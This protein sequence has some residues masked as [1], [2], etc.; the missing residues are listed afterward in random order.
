VVATIPTTKDIDSVFGGLVQTFQGYNRNVAAPRHG[1]STHS[2]PKPHVQNIIIHGSPASRGPGGPQQ[3]WK[4][5]SRTPPEEP[6]PNA[7]SIAEEIHLINQLKQSID[8]VHRLPKKKEFL[9]SIIYELENSLKIL[10]KLNSNFDRVNKNIEKSKINKD[11]YD[12]NSSY[13]ESIKTWHKSISN[14]LTFLRGLY[15]YLSNIGKYNFNNMNIGNRKKYDRFKEADGKL[16]VGLV[17]PQIH[18]FLDPLHRADRAL[19]SAFQA[20]ITDQIEKEADPAEGIVDFLL[21]YEFHTSHMS[22]T[23]RSMEK[24][25]LNSHRLIFRKGYAYAYYV[26]IKGNK[27]RYMNWRHDKRE[28]II[29]VRPDFYTSAG[30][31]GSG[32]AFRGGEDFIGGDTYVVGADDRFYAFLGTTIHSEY[33]SGHP[34]QAAGLI[35]AKDGKIQAIDNRSGHYQ[36]NWRNLLQAV[37]ILQNHQVFDREAIVGLVSPSGSVMFFTV[38]DCIELGNNNFSFEKTA[39]FVRHYKN[40]YN[41]NI[42]VPASRLKYIPERLKIGWNREENNRWDEF[43]IDFF[44]KPLPKDFLKSLHSNS[45]RETSVKIGGGR[46]KP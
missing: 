30:G 25:R 26:E 40:R 8:K 22:D 18:E 7:N 37:Q 16:I 20:W 33:F 4:R 43:F 23:S 35:V 12:K 44:G 41:G 36:P 11:L 28:E 1:A 21:N 46:S 19:A 24:D 2:P 34:V 29:L 45:P 9:H 13:I 15:K 17:H 39:L 32:P 27:V 14:T 31:G 6:R 5:A 10:D 42:P 3:T 38:D